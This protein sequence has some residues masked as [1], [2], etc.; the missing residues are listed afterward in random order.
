MRLE[1]IGVCQSCKHESHSNICGY[2]GFDEKWTLRNADVDP[3]YLEEDDFDIEIVFHD[4]CECDVLLTKH[5][6][7]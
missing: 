2:V 7:V 5:G 6:P 3:E 1:I 4:P